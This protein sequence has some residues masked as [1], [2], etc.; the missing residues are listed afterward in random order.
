MKLICFSLLLSV[1]VSAPFDGAMASPTEAA[2]P[3]TL[4]TVEHDTFGGGNKFKRK[5]RKKNRSLRRKH[6]HWFGR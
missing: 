2:A 3:A 5:K 1:L 4:T 6:S